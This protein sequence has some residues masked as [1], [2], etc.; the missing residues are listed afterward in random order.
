MSPESW[1]GWGRV[2]EIESAQPA[3]PTEK[4]TQMMKASAQTS[5]IPFLLKT[6]SGIRAGDG[7]IIPNFIFNAD[8]IDD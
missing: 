7:F 8:A 5:L 4:K 6:D 3:K 2:S 1:A